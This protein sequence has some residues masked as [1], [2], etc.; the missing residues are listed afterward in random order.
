MIEA[1]QRYD[2]PENRPSRAP[3]LNGRALR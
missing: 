2:R 1:I 3:Q